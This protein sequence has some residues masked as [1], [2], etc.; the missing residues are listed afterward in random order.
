M[1][2]VRDLTPAD[3]RVGADVWVAGFPCQP[4]STSGT[5]LGF[6][7]RD[8][9]VFE[10]LATLI[11][12]G[13]PPI[14]LLENVEGLLTN[15]AGHT[16]AVV[17]RRLTALE[18]N[19]EWV[20]VNLRWFGCPQSRPRLFILGYRDR[21][22]AGLQGREAK[23]SQVF[24]ELLTPLGV[25]CTA[26]GSGSLKAMERM[27]EPAIGKRHSRPPYPFGPAGLASGDTYRTFGYLRSSADPPIMPTL[28]EIVAPAFPHPETVRSVRYW[29]RG[30]PTRPRTRRDPISHCVGT[31]IGGAP[32]YAA[33]AGLVATTSTRRAFLE[34]ANWHRM[35]H[36]L[37]VMRLTPERA[38]LL[39]GPHVDRLHEAITAW[40][41]GATRKYKIVGNLVAPICAEAVGQ[42]LNARYV[43]SVSASSVARGRPPLATCRGKTLEER[44]GRA[45]VWRGRS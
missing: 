34:F 20:V 31:S 38:V 1:A 22:M 16:F 18:Y 5:R 6:G 28:A 10:K 26:R 3:L 4:F 27:L 33:P 39:F 37:S 19:V 2:D 41:T 8:G 23:P 43:S 35:E 30:K 15:K 13:L 29:A 36:G 24:A 25:V 17:L 21:G 42:M 7:H 40:T 44:N 11:A 12:E 14:V 32:L 45:V 9:H